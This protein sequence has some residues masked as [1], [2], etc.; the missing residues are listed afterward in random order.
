[1]DAAVDPRFGRCA[2][3]LVIDSESETVVGGGRNQFAS[4]AGGAGTRTA[5]WALELG[6]EVVLTGQVGPKAHDVLRAGKVRC[7]TGACGSVRE[8]LAAFARGELR[9]SG[10]TNPARHSGAQ[11]PRG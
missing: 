6:A 5:Q 11:G 3:L 10:P 1:M 2:C 4:S 7:L 9:E 8:A